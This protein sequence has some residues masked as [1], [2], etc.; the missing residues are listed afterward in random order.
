MP[1][2][3]KQE[4]LEILVKGDGTH[5]SEEDKTRMRFY[6]TSKRLIND[7]HRLAFE[8][9]YHVTSNTKDKKQGWG[10]GIHYVDISNGHNCMLNRRDV[11][12]IN[13]DGPVWCATVPNG[14][15]VT[16]RG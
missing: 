10:S 14:L 7:V 1:T 8:L 2:N 13:Y 15:L 4:L 6:S 12:R 3:L 5:Y 9:G 11:Q 16:R